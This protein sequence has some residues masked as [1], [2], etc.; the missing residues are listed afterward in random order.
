MNDGT[1][2]SRSLEDEL[3]LTI[4][5][6]EDWDSLKK[7]ISILN[8]KVWERR[9]DWMTVEQWLR[10][11]NG[12]S[13]V[14]VSI[15]RLHAL[16]LLSQMMYF[17]G[18][19]TR[20][21]LR[22]LFNDLVLVPL[23]QHVRSSVEDNRNISLIKD[24]T[25]EALKKTRF[26]GVGNPSESGVHLLYYFRQENELPKNF[27]LDSANIFTS[28]RQESGE[29]TTLLREPNIERYIFID[30]LCGS[31]ETAERYS[32]DLLPRILCLNPEV[33]LHYYSLFATS[34]GLERVRQKSL[35]GQRCGAVFELD[36]TYKCFSS[37]SRYLAVMPK[38]IQKSILIQVNNY[39]GGQLI[40]GHHNGFENGQLL[41]AFS[42]NTPDNTLPVIWA[43]AENGA[44]KPWVSAL[45]RYPKIGG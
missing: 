27:F 35:F 15:E 29:L 13:G 21:L 23:I 25:V 3:V 28:V 45:K 42:H 8:E 2:Q 22:S 17:G 26:L 33:E 4:E 9:L 16:Y 18:K 40:P 30:D 20:V 11:F 24:Q 10:N 19:E 7:R 44:R 6:R 36:E 43:E 34:R 32:Q 14:D 41:L 1:N 37:D 38:T 12:E 31:G 5:Q 39:H